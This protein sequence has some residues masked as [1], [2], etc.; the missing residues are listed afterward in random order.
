V[1]GGCDGVDSDDK[2]EG[3]LVRNDV[4]VGTLESEDSEMCARLGADGVTG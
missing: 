3:R 1:L 4:L 2:L